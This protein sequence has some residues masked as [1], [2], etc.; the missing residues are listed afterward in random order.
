[1]PNLKTVTLFAS[2]ILLSGCAFGGNSQ[3][4]T[5]V[6]KTTAPASSSSTLSLP[7]SDNGTGV[8]NSSVSG[9]VSNTPD[10][11]TISDQPAGGDNPYAPAKPPVLIEG[12]DGK[13]Y[14]ATEPKSE[15]EYQSDVASCHYYAEALIAHDA[16]VED[17]RGGSFN[18]DLG[19]GGSS[20]STLR[21]SINTQE[22]KQRQA[23]HFSRCMRSK[24][25]YQR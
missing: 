2:V 14:S 24:G 5:P 13:L 15:Q 7:P 3:K 16:R 17:D 25:Y 19:G 23:V 18:D 11:L 21:K 8:N 4:E 9:T 12:S 20:L 6:A 10:G 22:P 1:M